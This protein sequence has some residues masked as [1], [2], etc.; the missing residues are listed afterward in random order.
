MG[1][2][3]LEPSRQ[4][5]A[6]VKQEVSAENEADPAY[7]WTGRTTKQ[8]GPAWTSGRKRKAVAS[9]AD[10]EDPQWGEEM[11]EPRGGKAPRWEAAGAGG[12]GKRSPRDKKPSSKAA[13]GQTPQTPR[14]TFSHIDD[15]QCV[16]V[17][18]TMRACSPNPPALGPVLGTPVAATPART[19]PPPTSSGGDKA[20][21][22]PDSNPSPENATVI[23]NFIHAMLAQADEL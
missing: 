10:M 23:Y 16:Q 15:E 14:G 20:E 11:A 18:L 17:L 6:F 5:G 19:P 22:R 3:L 21:E 4:G 1:V 9:Y 8:D 2:D 7:E 12:G 13:A